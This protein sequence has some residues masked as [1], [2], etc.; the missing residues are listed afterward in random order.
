[1]DARFFLPGVFNTRPGADKNGDPKDQLED[2]QWL[3]DGKQLSFIY[4][5]MLYVVPADTQGPK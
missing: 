1:M 4:Q 2:I 5:G 3:P